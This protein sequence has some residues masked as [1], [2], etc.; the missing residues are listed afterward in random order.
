MINPDSSG[1]V[2]PGFVGLVN[3]RIFDLG[4]KWEFQSVGQFIRRVVRSSANQQKPDRHNPK[5]TTTKKVP[6]NKAPPPRV[7]TTMHLW[8]RTKNTSRT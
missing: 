2:N 8:K 3:P 5:Y 6:K 1:L 4:H 7:S